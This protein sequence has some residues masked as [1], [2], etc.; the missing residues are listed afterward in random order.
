M[1]IERVKEGTKEGRERISR[2]VSWSVH[3]VQELTGLKLGEVLKSGKEVVSRVERK[4]EKEIEEVGHEAKK[5]AETV[6]EKNVQQIED[7]LDKKV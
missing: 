4:V 6:I 5:V 1:L 7:E 2:G 3:K